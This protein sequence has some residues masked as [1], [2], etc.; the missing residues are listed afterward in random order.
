MDIPTKRNCRFKKL[1]KKHNSWWQN[2]IELCT[3]K[4]PARDVPEPAKNRDALAKS[5]SLSVA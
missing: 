3:T 1:L 4:S 5:Q 2:I